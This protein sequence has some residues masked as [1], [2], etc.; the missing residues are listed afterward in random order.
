MPSLETKDWLFFYLLS[1]SAQALDIPT[2]YIA[3][4]YIFSF[5]AVKQIETFSFQFARGGGGH[6]PSE[7]TAN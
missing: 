1:S 7:P 2:R 6:C 4:I 3:V 5:Y